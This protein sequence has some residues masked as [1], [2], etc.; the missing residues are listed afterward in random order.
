MSWQKAGHVDI[1][2]VYANNLKIIFQ[3]YYSRTRYCVSLT[4]ERILSNLC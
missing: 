4:T 3:D 1:K 2:S